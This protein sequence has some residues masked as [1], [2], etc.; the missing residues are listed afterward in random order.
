MR[1]QRHVQIIGGGSGRR[2]D[3]AGR[4]TDDQKVLRISGMAADER[5]RLLTVSGVVVNTGND[6]VAGSDE[7]TGVDFLDRQFDAFTHRRANECRWPRQ[8]LNH[9]DVKIGGVDSRKAARQYE[10]GDRRF[11][12]ILHCSIPL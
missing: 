6:S 7:F 11:Q 12:K 4:R 10:C 9:R 2:R 1:E 5:K 8:G 3:G